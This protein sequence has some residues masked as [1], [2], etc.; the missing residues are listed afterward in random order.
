MRP[1]NN[2]RMSFKMW[3]EDG[4]GTRPIKL[5]FM[6]ESPLP[7]VKI[8]LLVSMLCDQSSKHKSSP[9]RKSTDHHR[10]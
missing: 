6:L 1:K 2:G 10:L 3:G 5:S 7:V 4:N 8:N 9:R